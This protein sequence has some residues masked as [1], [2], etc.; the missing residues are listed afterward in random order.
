MMES[1]ITCTVG[2]INCTE[3]FQ[4]CNDVLHTRTVC[5]VPHQAPNTIQKFE[6]I[7]PYVHLMSR[8]MYTIARDQFTIT[9]STL[10][11]QVTN[12]GTR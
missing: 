10:V 9:S 2:L 6:A 1:I 7:P 4:E 8:Y 11:L 3:Y 12:N 5:T